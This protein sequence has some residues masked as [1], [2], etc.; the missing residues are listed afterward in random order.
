MAA[1]TS[2]LVRIEH[3]GASFDTGV[4][5]VTSD[6]FKV[7]GIDARAGR[8]IASPDD[9]LSAVAVLSDR[10][11]TRMFGDVVHLVR[12]S[13]WTAASPDHRVARRDFIGVRMDGG[14]DLFV[15]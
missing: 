4:K 5:G 10:L 13:S 6:Y 7:L 3:N 8:V 2:S 9:P 15:R 12:R 1:F 14:V 11:A